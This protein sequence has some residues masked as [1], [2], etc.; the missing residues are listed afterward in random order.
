MK[1]RINMAFG[2]KAREMAERAKKREESG[3]EDKTFVAPWVPI[4]GSPTGTV[5][6]IVQWLPEVKDGE[7][8]TTPRLSPTTGEPLREGNKKTGKVLVKPVPA[9]EVVFSYAW[10]NVM[11][12]GSPSPRRIILDPDNWKNVLRQHI[13]DTGYAR[14]SKE[15]KSIK[16]AF[17]ANVYDQS[18]VVHMDDGRVFYGS[19]KV[20]N[21]LA[22]KPN[23]TVVTDKDKLPSPDQAASASP[24]NEVRIIEGSYGKQG[25][26]HFFAQ[27]E[28]LLDVEDADGLSRTL[29]EFPLKITVNGTELDTVRSVRNMPRFI[30]P[31]KEVAL[32]PRYDLKTWLTPWPD[33]MVTRLL[34][35]EDFNEL[36]EEYHIVLYP[37]LIAPSHEAYTGDTEK[38]D[39]DQEELFD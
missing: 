35:G 23:G 2:G 4:G 3:G 27:F 33:E 22:G 1:G 31:D 13:L 5:V 29:T 21:I 11:V 30:T 9:S 24:L 18:P 8:V 28:D 14:D 16:T 19:G 17:A 15:Y 36:V 37:T 7:I 38:L 20:F 6:R 34:D 32:Q 25:G 26:K 12:N 10:W 39:A